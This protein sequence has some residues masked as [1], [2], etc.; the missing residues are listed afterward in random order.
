MDRVLGNTVVWISPTECCLFPLAEGDVGNGYENLLT[1]L[2]YCCELEPG[3]SLGGVTV[4]I[5][6]QGRLPS[7]TQAWDG[8]AGGP[9][10]WAGAT[11]PGSILSS[12]PLTPH[13]RWCSGS[14]ELL[15][16]PCSVT[17]LMLTV[18]LA[19]ETWL[20]LIS[21]LR[22]WAWSLGQGRDSHEVTGWPFHSQPS[23][24]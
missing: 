15:L 12:A 18:S 6:L 23:W 19:L 11:W 4:S 14:P 2:G 10:C 8:G 16:I 9:W 24:K 22:S 13:L 7:V 1:F 17:D 20:F 5:A 3:W 21:R